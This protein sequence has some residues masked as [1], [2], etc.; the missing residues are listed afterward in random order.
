MRV[1]ITVFDII[2]HY[3]IVER[4]STCKQ[5]PEDHEEDGKR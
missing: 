1:V 4:V 2:T 3:L 5:H